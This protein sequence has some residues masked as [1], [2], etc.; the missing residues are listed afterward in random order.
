MAAP[1][2][3]LELVERFDRDKAY[4]KSG[5]YSE[6]Q[7]RLD[8]I[9]PFFEAL[10]WDIR[11]EEGVP[12]AARD[13]IVEYSMKIGAATKAPDY[14]FRQGQQN[15]FFVEAKRPSVNVREDINPAFQLRSY[16]WTDGM[17]L[18]ILTDFEELAVYDCR[19]V[20]NKGDKAAV[21]RTL[22]IPYTEYAARWGEIVEL[23]S[24][25]AVRDGSLDKFAQEQRA[26]KGSMPLDAAFLKEIEGW[27]EVLARN[28]AIW[29]PVLTQRG[30]NYAIQMTIDRIIFLRISEDRG[31]EPYGRLRELLEGN[32]VYERLCQQF[33]D[34]DARY[35]SGLFHFQKEKGREDPDSWTLGLYIED[36]P[37][38]KI[39]KSIYY[40]DSPY[41]FSIIPVETLGNVY[42]QFL[43]KVIYLTKDHRANIEEKPEVRKAGG[44][45]YTPA[46]I[47]D[48]IIKHTLGKLLEGR[49]PKEAAKLRIVD[50]AC[51]SGSF[52]ISAYQFLLDWY[53]DQYVAAGP[54]K[55]RTEIHQLPSGEWRLLPAERKRILL[56]NVYGV[57]ID[58]QAVEVTKLSLSLKILEGETQLQL[59]QERALPDLGNNIKCGNSL[60]G[61]DFYDN[62]QTSF[63]DDEEQYRINTFDWET[64]FP[65]IMRAGGFDAVI[66]NPPWISL[67]GKFGND[68]YSETEITY[69]TKRYQGNT[70][71]PNMYEYFVSEGLNLTR[72]GGYFSFIVPD[73]LGFNGQFVRLRERILKETRILSLAYK[74][75]F[76]G[77]VAD[78]LV[79]ALHREECDGSNLVTVFQYGRPPLQRAQSDFLAASNYVFEFFTDLA[80]M[81][82]ANKIAN[83]PRTVPLEKVY[84]STSGFGGKSQLITEGQTSIN[85]IQ[86][87]KG[88]SIGRYELRKIYWFDFKKENITGR[89]T[90]KTKLGAK[91]K[92]LLRKTGDRIIA[93]YDESGIFPEQSLY[94]LFN[95]NTEL[96]VKFILGVLNSRLLTFYFRIK[97][98]TNKESIAQV[99]KVDLD[100]LPIPLLE[101]SNPSSKARHDEMVSLVERMLDYRKRLPAVNTPQERMIIQRQIENTDRQIDNLVYDLYG[102]LPDERNIVEEATTK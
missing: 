99:K 79:F 77:I 60:I 20:P 32:N 25:E 64:G 93:T 40:P 31:I 24:W 47:V 61:S 63:L 45:Y 83:L 15:K 85:Q 48:Y 17:P 94:F 62:P 7:V 97:A 90:D 59:F 37:L 43:G 51:G 26:P 92:I 49:T 68:I 12:A 53:R 35:N 88:D 18:S 86:T 4:Y 96:D 11:N 89:T 69:L 58:A 41:A 6:A 1:D 78:T 76:P 14:L 36:E 56:N 75:P 98:L 101:L 39:I 100:Q 65:E 46:Y 91:P 70:Y 21:A 42:E 102:L 72:K 74:M 34:A 95:K 87:L 52:L 80:V 27:R 55:H 50:P 44:V 84:S 13:V 22:Y 66:G 5:V 3:I 38:K 19:V 71:M 30:L 9:D 54:R 28:I 33:R 8:F 73:R 10:G 16:A 82:L 57:D 29:N 2:S 81:D 67:T 23:F